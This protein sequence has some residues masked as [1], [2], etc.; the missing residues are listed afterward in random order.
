MSVFNTW[1]KRPQY[2]LPVLVVALALLAL[3]GCAARPPVRPGAAPEA[4]SGTD[5]GVLFTQ[6]SVTGTGS[7]LDLRFRVVDEQKA[8][9]WMADPALRPHLVVERTGATL[10]PPPPGAHVHSGMVFGRQYYTFYGNTRGAVQPG[11]GILLQIS[12]RTVGRLLAQ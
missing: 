10:Y 11:D 3:Q 5:Y 7:W 1:P 4:D 8:M 12:G 9:S 6:L 2:I